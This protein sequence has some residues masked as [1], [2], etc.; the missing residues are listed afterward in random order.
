MWINK[1]IFNNVF[2]HSRGLSIYKVSSALIEQ[3]QSHFLPPSDA[4][5]QGS[6]NLSLEVQSAAEFSSNPDQTHLP[7]IL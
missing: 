3:I 6:S 2:L 4:L 5:D 7:V 1:T